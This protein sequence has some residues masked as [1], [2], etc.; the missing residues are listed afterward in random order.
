MQAKD[1]DPVVLLRAVD[2][3]QRTHPNRQDGSL[4][5]CYWWDVLPQMPDVPPGVVYAKARR[6]LDRGLLDACIHPGK[7]QCRGDLELTAAGRAAAH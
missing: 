6:L 3:G 4:R 5:W 2:A 7:L 1:L